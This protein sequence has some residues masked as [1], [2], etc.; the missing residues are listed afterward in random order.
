MVTDAKSY[1][2]PG[3]AVELIVAE[4]LISIYSIRFDQG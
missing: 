4:T 3:N 1:S 2:A